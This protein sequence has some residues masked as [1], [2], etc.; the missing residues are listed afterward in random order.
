MVAEVT[1]IA[2]P[3]AALLAISANLGPIMTTCN[4][5]MRIGGSTEDPASA[6]HLFDR[7][8]RIALIL[9]LYPTLC[10]TYESEAFRL[11]DS[12]KKSDNEPYSDAEKKRLSDGID[13]INTCIKI[14]DERNLRPGALHILYMHRAYMECKLGLLKDARRSAENAYEISLAYDSVNNSLA[15]NIIRAAVSYFAHDFVECI[16]IFRIIMENFLTIH[17][18]KI[19]QNADFLHVHPLNIGFSSGIIFDVLRDIKRNTQDKN[20]QTKIMQEIVG[21]IITIMTEYYAK[22]NEFNDLWYSLYQVQHFNIPELM[23]TY[24]MLISLAGNDRENLVEKFK[25]SRDKLAE[26]LAKH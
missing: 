19:D 21:S 12:L 8:K 4:I 7:A 6:N 22:A 23:P 5:L 25:K 3:S 10:A 17:Q 9:E 1:G 20:R 13:Q 14:L 18:N 26:D 15:A 16:R 24:D 2:D 11:L